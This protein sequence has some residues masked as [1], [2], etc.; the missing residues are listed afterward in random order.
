MRGG[1]NLRIYFEGFMDTEISYEEHLKELGDLSM[2]ESDFR[3]NMKKELSDCF[4]KS[5]LNENE[6]LKLTNLKVVKDKAVK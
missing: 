2:T 4:K 3:K 5:Y 1:L 6:R